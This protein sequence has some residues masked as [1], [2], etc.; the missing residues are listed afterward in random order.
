M[1]DLSDTAK[2]ALARALADK[3]SAL[4]ADTTAATDQTA[5]DAATA[6]A[7]ASH[8]A[9]TTANQTALTSAAA[10]V[11]LV[12]QELGLDPTPPAP[13]PPPQTF[14]AF[15]PHEAQAAPVG[16]IGDRWRKLRQVQDGVMADPRFK[17]GG[18]VFLTLLAKLIPVILEEIGSGKTV[19]QI[20]TDILA[21]L[22]PS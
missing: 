12:R 22:F 16:A 8:A 2:A 11:T 1:F 17:A 7:A 10:F 20:I 5:A 21:A 6:K 3:Q 14:G 15:L 13:T 4:D 18:A 19:A 9:D